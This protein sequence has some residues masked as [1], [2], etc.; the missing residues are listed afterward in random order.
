MKIKKLLQ[1]TNYYGIPG[2]VMIESAQENLLDL[3]AGLNSGPDVYHCYG[4]VNWSKTKSSVYV[5]VVQY[6][7]WTDMGRPDGKLPKGQR[8]VYVVEEEDCVMSNDE[9]VEMLMK[10]IG[11]G[12][13]FN[14]TWG[15]YGVQPVRVHVVED[16]GDKFLFADKEHEMFSIDKDLITTCTVVD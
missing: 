15:K 4:Y 9:C 13:K 1:V 5:T 8:Y 6:S 7:F 12:Q 16:K 11:T 2:N 14:I 3:I 10:S